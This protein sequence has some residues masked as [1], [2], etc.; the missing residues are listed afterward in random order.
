MVETGATIRRLGA[1]SD[2]AP[3]TLA[4]SIASVA[5][6]IDTGVAGIHR[7]HGNIATNITTKIGTVI[8]KTSHGRGLPFRRPTSQQKSIAAR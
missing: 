6:A 4:N 5:A 8:H 1:W 2:T 7:H 3:G